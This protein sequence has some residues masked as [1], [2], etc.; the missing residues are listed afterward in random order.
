MAKPES[1]FDP[2]EIFTAT[3]MFFTASELYAAKS[4]ILKLVKIFDDSKDKLSSIEFGT[5]QDRDSFS[6]YFDF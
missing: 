6:S 2:T 3:S 4:D 5:T 1:G